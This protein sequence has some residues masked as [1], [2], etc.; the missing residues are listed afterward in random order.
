MIIYPIGTIYKRAQEYAAAEK[1]IAWTWSLP[2]LLLAGLFLFQHGISIA[3]VTFIA[4][5]A[6]YAKCVISKCH[7]L[8]HVKGHKWAGSKY[9]KWLEDIHLL[10][11]WD[12]RCNFTIVNPL[13]DKLFGTYLNPKEHQAELN[14]AAIEDAF[15][16]SDMINWRYLLLEAN[17]EEYA[18]YISEAKE[19][20]KSI[21]KLEELI[22][23]LGEEHHKNP[24]DPEVKLLLKRAKKLESLLN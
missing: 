6:W 5:V 11:H 23:V 7:K 10:H 20:K 24:H 22:C 8:F 16:V 14:I 3:T 21:K 2:G 19:H 18:A 9:F 17:P 12:Q 4:A 15:T 1:G 13:M